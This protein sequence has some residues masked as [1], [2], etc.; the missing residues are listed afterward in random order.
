MKTRLLLTSAL[1]VFVHMTTPQAQVTVDASKITC[2]QLIMEKT[3]AGE[4]RR[5][6]AQWVLQQ[7]AQQHDHRTRIYGQERGEG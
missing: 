6:M 7:Q 1:F 3:R 5:V 4:V 2:E